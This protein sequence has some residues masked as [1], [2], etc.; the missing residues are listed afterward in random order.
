M[1]SPVPEP[2]VTPSPGIL[3]KLSRYTAALLP[4]PRPPA[5]PDAGR[6]PS[7]QPPAHLQSCPGAAA[8]PGRRNT[9]LDTRGAVVPPLAPRQAPNSPRAKRGVASDTKGAL[10]R[11]ASPMATTRGS[12][13]QTSV[14]NLTSASTVSGAN[15]TLTKP[16]GKYEQSKKYFGPLQAAVPRPTGKTAV[17]YDKGGCDFRFCNLS[18]LGPQKV[19]WPHMRSG[20]NATFAQFD[21]FKLEPSRSP[22]PKYWLPGATGKQVNSTKPTRPI[23][24]F[25][26]G[27]R[28]GA[29][30]QYGVWSA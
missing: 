21:R 1:R 17:I 15:F 29:L 12:L 14:P 6:A 25:G 20:G 23:V 13:V 27:T 8:A 24:G 26:T 7:P 19:S 5:D 18:C 22:G 2:L 28:D 4:L 9:A 10:H 11:A 3:S 30:K 16:K